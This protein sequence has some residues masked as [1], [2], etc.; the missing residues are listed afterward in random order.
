MSA[1]SMVLNDLKKGHIIGTDNVT[2]ST[3]G[4]NKIPDVIYKLRKR[5]HVIETLEKQVISRGVT[6]K[7]AEYR[8]VVSCA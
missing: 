3:Y 5:G 2:A 7:V 6:K 4:T 1:T 8:M